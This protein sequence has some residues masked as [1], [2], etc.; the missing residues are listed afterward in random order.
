MYDGDLLALTNVLNDLIKKHEKLGL[1][2]ADGTASHRAT[3][4]DMVIADMQTLGLWSVVIVILALG[5]LFRN[6]LGVLAPVLV[7]GVSVV[8]ALGFMALIGYP[9]TILSGILPAFLFCVGVGDSIH[10]L[11]I[12]RDRRRMGIANEEAIVE[13]VAITGPPV[14]FTSVTTTCGLLSLGFASVPAIV[15]MGIAGGV[16][17][18]VAFIMSIWLLPI[19]LLLNRS[20]RL[21][22]AEKGKA[23]RL[24]R[25]VGA[26]LYFSDPQSGPRR[27]IRVLGIGALLAVVAG[28]G[29]SRLDVMHDDLATVPQD[30]DVRRAADLMDAGWVAW[31][32]PS[33]WLRPPMG[34][35][36]TLTSYVD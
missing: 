1:D 24:D 27:H 22:A 15:E 18:M 9:L 8:W 33:C 20:G 30:S 13:A 35:S 34:Q 17:V 26:C 11:S 5:F 29:M 14:F 31:R 36:K 2:L 7:V 25:F 19:L 3:L 10:M 32:R 12:Y 21:G 6:V 4:N 28:L 23:D 16:G